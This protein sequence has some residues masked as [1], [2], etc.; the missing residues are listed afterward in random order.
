MK[1]IL[2][3]NI[4]GIGDVLF[5]TPLIVNLKRN[6]TGV[7]I[8]YLCNKRAFDVLK[9][10]PEIKKI[11]IY[12]KDHFVRLWRDSRMKCLKEL[13]HLFDSI[14]KRQYD[15]VFDFTLSRKFGVFFAFCGIS[16]RIGLD[17]KKRGTLLTD[18]MPFSGFK[19]K[20]VVDHYL[21][22]LNFI[23]LPAVVSQLSLFPDDL[24]I[25][26]LADLWNDREKLKR[27]LISV[28]PGGGASWG[29][30]ASRKRWKVEKFAKVAD[31]LIDKGC[32]VAVVGDKNEAGL[33]QDLVMNMK[34]M[35][36]MLENDFSLK[37]YIAF[38]SRCS[39]VLC[40]D[41]GPLH[42]AAALG[43]KTV[44][45]FGPV[46]EN[47]YGPYPASKKHRVAVALKVKCRPCYSNFR[48]PACKG[49][50]RCLDEIMPEKVANM[51]FESLG[52]EV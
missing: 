38:L 36:V 9:G 17:Y 10:N 25:E 44:S 11:F 37:K 26:D 39:L 51:C 21:D 7:E 16:R 29:K 15:A 32:D 27:P 47:V 20:H 6:I 31:L 23:K 33:C 34:N 41:G 35:P 2:I 22:L 1:K 5:T 12:E 3:A 43:I 30:E 48:L 8:D 13:Y 46:D 42:V 45:I 49:D 14:R 50:N 28:I 18:K 24:A 19:D 40:N 52:I 4:F